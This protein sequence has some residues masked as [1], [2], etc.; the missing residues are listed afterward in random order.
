[1]ICVVFE[2]VFTMAL[3]T[4]AL[5]YD[6]K[7]VDR[8]QL[9][10][11]IDLVLQK[12]QQEEAV[13]NEIHAREATES[14]ALQLEE[15]SSS[16]SDSS[17]HEIPVCTMREQLECNS[18]INYNQQSMLVYI[19]KREQY[20]QCTTRLFT[21]N[22]TYEA[23]TASKQSVLDSEC[24]QE[25]VDY[26]FSKILP[27]PSNMT[28]YARIVQ[29]QQE[30]EMILD[31]VL[32]KIT[33]KQY[34]LVK[35]TVT[36][37]NG[38]Q[39][40]KR[41]LTFSRE[42]LRQIVHLMGSMTKKE[43][44]TV[45]SVSI[46]EFRKAFNLI[47]N[48]IHAF[49]KRFEHTID[50]HNIRC[51]LKLLL[52]SD[53]FTKMLKQ[54]MTKHP[55]HPCLV[56]CVSLSQ[57]LQK[58]IEFLKTLNM[59]YNDPSVR[60]ENAIAQD[61]MKKHKLPSRHRKPELS[62][63]GSLVKTREKPR[64]PIKRMKNTRKSTYKS[65]TTT[66]TIPLNKSLKADE[67]MMSGV[68]GED[69]P[70]DHSINSSVVCEEIMYVKSEIADSGDGR[71]PY[72]KNV[73]LLCIVHEENTLDE[74]ES[75]NNLSIPKCQSDM[76]VF[77]SIREQRDQFLRTLQH[78]HLYVNRHFTRPWSVLSKIGESLLDELIDSIKNQ[79]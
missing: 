38:S 36:D 17:I 2:C 20:S 79:L 32:L 39:S 58:I 23:F 35:R 10:R 63:Y 15:I 64:I 65:T 56:S 44:D 9:Q 52:Y 16:D 5:N 43:N 33:E 50:N 55:E 68:N 19:E 78:N 51:L 47:L 28:V 34:F 49:Q 61:S 53:N 14:L 62:M 26:S 54:K 27:K 21:N 74:T 24:V 46:K 37:I 67:P 73:Q 12:R 48:S 29:L 4:T 41:T 59:Q 30:I 18:D 7:Y 40:C 42:Y 66:T 3:K 6:F 8:F 57:K 11:I 72:A 76:N 22:A 69:D 71:M 60:F 25:T 77:A 70:I 75:V 45:G 31:E 1:M 13:G